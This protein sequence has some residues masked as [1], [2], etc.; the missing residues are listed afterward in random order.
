MGNFHH[1]FGISVS[2]LYHFQTAVVTAPRPMSSHPVAIG[3]YANDVM[4][5]APNDK[6]PVKTAHNTGA[7]QN[8]ITDQKV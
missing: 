7:I 5:S 3:A 1:S 6:A 4:A 2:K 8:A